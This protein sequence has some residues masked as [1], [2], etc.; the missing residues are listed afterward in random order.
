[1]KCSDYSEGYVCTQCGSII[2]CYLNKEVRKREST[3]I[4]A[5]GAGGSSSFGYSVNT[6]VYCR[7]CDRYQCK[8]VAIPYV[9]RYMTNELAAM[10]IKL[11]F[12]LDT[13]QVK[14]TIVKK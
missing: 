2:S 8:K 12:K 10:N 3:T 4:E 5:P 1:M 14:E 11:K 13:D 7:S 9:L 6:V